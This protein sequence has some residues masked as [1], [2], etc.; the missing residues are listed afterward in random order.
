[1]ES[2]KIY[3]KKDDKESELNLDGLFIEI[4][5]KTNTKLV[6]GLVKKNEDGEIMVDDSC[7]TNVSGLFAAGDTTQVKFK[8]IPIAVG[9]GTISALSSYQYIQLKKT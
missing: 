9:Q 8:Q 2:V 5:R 1:M 4:G 6:D 3:N 7:E